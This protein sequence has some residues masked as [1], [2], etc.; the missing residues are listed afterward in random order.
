VVRIRTIEA[1][2]VERLRDVDRAAGRLFAAVGMHDVAAHE[3]PP[4][5]ELL[6]YRRAGRAWAAV[7]DDDE[8]VAYV[9]V[10]VVDGCAHVEQI[11]VHPEAGR[12]GIGG[13]LLDIVASW[14]R[15]EGMPALTLITFRHVAWN[16]PYYERLGFRALT[17]GELGPEL[18]T[19]RDAESA[20]GLD[21]AQRVCMR[22]DL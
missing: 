22:R 20:K 11:S 18:R 21:P 8:P 10:D 2:D 5:E 19:L 3:P 9:V 4:A 13:R 14:A 12:Q 6:A 16:R 15:T 1:A 17:D 7:D